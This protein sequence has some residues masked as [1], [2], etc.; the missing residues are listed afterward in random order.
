MTLTKFLTYTAQEDDDSTFLNFMEL[1][2]TT[3]T[4]AWL[5]SQPHLRVLTLDEVVRTIN[6]DVYSFFDDHVVWVNVT[7]TDEPDIQIVTLHRGMLIELRREE[8]R[9]QFVYTYNSDSGYCY[10][11]IDNRE[12]QVFQTRSFP[13]SH[14]AIGWLKELRDPLTVLKSQIRQ[15]ADEYS[16]KRSD[17]T[18]ILEGLLDT[19]TVD[20]SVAE[21]RHPS[22][23]LTK[24]VPKGSVVEYDTLTTLFTVLDPET[25]VLIESSEMEH[26]YE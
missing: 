21:H 7:E 26:M 10:E 22:C 16:E 1:N 23:R 8:N 13:T 9:G 24:D 6:E 15:I 14:E 17:V 12:G 4:D 5:Q 3:V 2:G 20:L 19:G 18:E 25:N 11:A